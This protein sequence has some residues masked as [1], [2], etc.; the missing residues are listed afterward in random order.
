MGIDWSQIANPATRQGLTATTVSGLINSPTVTVQGIT[1]TAQFGVNLVTWLGQTPATLTGAGQNLVQS[2]AIV[3][4]V[5]SVNL[6]QIAG[7]P[8]VGTAGYVGIDWAQITN[9]TTRQGL[10]A[11][12]I[13][14]LIN[15]PVVTIS[16]ITS[17]AQFGVNVVTW[18]GAAPSPL[19]NGLVQAT[20][21]GTTP[22]VNVVSWLGATPA[23]ITAAGNV[24]VDVEQWRSVVPNTLASGRVNST[25]GQ[26]QS[27]GISTI[28]FVPG[29]LTTTVF[30]APFLTSA[31]YDTSYAKQTRRRARQPCERG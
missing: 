8:T 26:V 25:V 31:S 19:V 20:F 12:T 9:Q 1:S 28:A 29:A 7:S 6:T 18:E 17:Q 21:S 15:S 11:T 5:P 2:Q 30:A 22:G 4:G 23:P 10:T 14:G 13:S 16:G 3:S 27:G 24:Q